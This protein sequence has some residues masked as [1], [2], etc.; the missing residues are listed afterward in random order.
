MQHLAFCAF[1]HPGLVANLLN[2]QYWQEN[3]VLVN[4]TTCIACKITVYKSKNSHWLHATLR[5][6]FSSLPW[7]VVYI[8]SGVTYTQQIFHQRIV[9]T[10]S[11]LAT[12]SCLAVFFYFFLNKKTLVKGAQKEL[13]PIYKIKVLLLVQKKN[14]TKNS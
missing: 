10:R 8:L 14:I 3:K 12:C 13:C 11:I 9:Y 2:C 6:W 4:L 5:E 7:I 1:L